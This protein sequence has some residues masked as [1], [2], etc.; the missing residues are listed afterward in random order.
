MIKKTTDPLND[1]AIQMWDGKWYRLGHFDYHQCC[2]C[3]LVHQVDYRIERGTI[4]ERWRVD[5]RET[6]KV[7]KLLGIAVTVKR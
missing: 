7:R 1:G 6:A 5:K 4:F 3:G 2:S